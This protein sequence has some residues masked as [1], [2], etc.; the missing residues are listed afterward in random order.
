MEETV[1]LKDLQ[2]ILTVYPELDEWYYTIQTFTDPVKCN[3]KHLKQILNSIDNNTH[4]LYVYNTKCDANWKQLIKYTK[5]LDE[6]SIIP[7]LQQRNE[8]YLTK[9]QKIN[10]ETIKHILNSKFEKK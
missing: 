4:K 3:L 2:N 7:H 10:M 6:T 1:T 9:S 5:N 8:N